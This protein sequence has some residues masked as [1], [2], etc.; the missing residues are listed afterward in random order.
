MVEDMKTTSSKEPGDYQPTKK[1][2]LED[3]CVDLDCISD[4]ES[5]HQPVA[6]VICR[7]ALN[8][9]WITE[10]EDYFIFVIQ[11]PEQIKLEVSVISSKEVDIKYTL[12]GPKMSDLKPK[13]LT[14]DEDHLAIVFT[15]LCDGNTS[16][17]LTGTFSLSFPSPV[18]Q[19]I[20]KWKKRTAEREGLFYHTIW[21]PKYED[22]DETS[23][24]L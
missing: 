9:T 22:E 23:F 7:G 18:K 20:T 8:C 13:K 21:I 1:R 12:P 10:T 16:M 14:I 11:K 17:D 19:K 24:T 3:D 4:S 6:R 2:K 5:N 15:K